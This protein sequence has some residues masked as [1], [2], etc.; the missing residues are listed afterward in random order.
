VGSL[1]TAGAAPAAPVAAIAPVVAIA[2]AA[3]SD[4]IRVN[5]DA[6]IALLS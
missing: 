4:P 2:A 5:S 3:A 6:R 1:F